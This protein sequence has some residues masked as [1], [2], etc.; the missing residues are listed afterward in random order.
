MASSRDEARAFKKLCTLKGYVS[1]DSEHGRRES[2]EEVGPLYHAYTN[3]PK[4]SF[5]AYKSNPMKA[6]EDLIEKIRSEQ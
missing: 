6:V 3:N 4:P 2:G 5:S 1:L